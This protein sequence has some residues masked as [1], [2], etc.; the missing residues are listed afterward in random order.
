MQQTAAAPPTAA[1]GTGQN[2]RGTAITFLSQRWALDQ[3]IPNGRGAAVLDVGAADGSWLRYLEAKRFAPI[4]A[5]EHHA[6][7]ATAAARLGY[8]NVFCCTAEAVPLECCSVQVVF[9]HNV[10]T[11][12]TDR[13]AKIRTLRRLSEVCAVGGVI[14]ANHPSTLAYYGHN[15]YEVND[16]VSFADVDEFTRWV[17]AADPMLQ[18]RYTPPPWWIWA[19]RKTMRLPGIPRIAFWT[20]RVWSSRVLPASASDLLYYKIDKMA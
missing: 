15:G 6:E 9:A 16:Y 19:L 14:I 7:R 13:D 10:L 18:W 2:A 1:G 17:T 3:F 20:D 8:T 5:V 11:L 4:Y 12:I